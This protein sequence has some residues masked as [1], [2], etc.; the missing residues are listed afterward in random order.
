MASLSNPTLLI[1]AL[2]ATFAYC[3]TVSSTDNFPLAKRSE[4]CDWAQYFWAD[5]DC[6]YDFHD[7]YEGWLNYVVKIEPTGQNT[8][9]GWCKGIID[10]IIG[11]CGRNPSN[12][13]YLGGNDWKGCSPYLTY[14]LHHPVTYEV[15]PMQGL[16]LNFHYHWPWTEGEDARGCI[17]N[18]IRKGSCAGDVSF[19]NGGCYKRS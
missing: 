17:E 7:E 2:I 1:P 10:N 15:K 18:A 11:E 8:G 5:V 19:K 14:N 9:D 3:T 13:A 16:D 6:Y 12:I 4:D